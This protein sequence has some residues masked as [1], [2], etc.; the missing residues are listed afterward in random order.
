MMAK[1]K[2]K[3]DMKQINKFRFWIGLGVLSLL[4]LVLTYFQITF[5]AGQKE[6][7]AYLEKE[8]AVKGL[9]DFKN[10]KFLPSW[11]EREEKLKKQR[12][13]IWGQA[14]IPQK[15]IQTWFKRDE[16]WEKKT[17]SKT[18]KLIWAKFDP[19]VPDKLAMNANN[20][21]N[22]K[23]PSE[24]IDGTSLDTYKDTLYLAQF[25]NFEKEL[26]DD[27]F[28]VEFNN[29]FDSLMA[30]IS[31]KR[32]S[33]PTAEEV[34]IAQEN[35]WV[36]R[37]LIRDIRNAM[38]SIS[39]MVPDIVAKDEPAPP[40][41]VKARK[42]FYNSMWE[43]DVMFE[44]MDRDKFI[45][46]RTKIMNVHQ[47]K[48][49]LTLDNPIA[50]TT[51][52]FLLRQGTTTFSLKAQGE[53]LGFGQP[54]E[55]VKDKLPLPFSFDLNKDFTLEQVYTFKNTPIKM[56]Q[57]LELGRTSHR[58]SNVKL[59]HRSANVL[60][61]ETGGAEGAEGDNAAG[62]GGPGMP[63]GGPGMPP[64]GSG[65][66]MMGEG[67][68]MGMRRGGMGTSSVKDPTLINGIDRS[69][70]IH[71]TDQCRHL[72][73][74]MSLILDQT[75]M[76]EV[77]ASLANSK[78]RIQ[79]TQFH[80]Q[81]LSGYKNSGF[82]AGAAGPAGSA[83]AGSGGPGFSPP[84][85]GMRPAGPGGRPMGSEDGGMRP[86]PGMGGGGGPG[87]RPT[88][89]NPNLPN[90]S[91]NSSSVGDVNLVEINLYGV[92]S[93]FEKPGAPPIVPDNPVPGSETGSPRQ[94]RGPSAPAREDK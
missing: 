44:T 26:V 7:K 79:V 62:P 91:N 80:Y 55:F 38:R 12:D 93:L 64:G 3:I 23:F 6:R 4:L 65:M 40:P 57:N 59:V 71:A 21:A 25:H 10:D 30:P 63:P 50:G 52:E 49:I 19:N 76:N 56:I 77:L 20:E 34:W 37:E 8:K 28:P 29:G 24:P 36:K 48:R 33:T 13:E 46:P 45:S 14:W 61:K 86:P 39:T 83:D 41:E 90:S 5:S 68:G 47:D 66:P 73:F 81:H 67:G 11:G 17:D 16:I 51:T 82:I 72:P 85:G 70:Y 78:L 15:D 18:G 54:R 69:I 2:I 32:G 43:V 60:K 22:W 35:F 74:A 94:P 31:W 42:R 1:A 92:A 84:G 75:I 89:G 87:F 58:L 53:P 27:R 88:V 9:N